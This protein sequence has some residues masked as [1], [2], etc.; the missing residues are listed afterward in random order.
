MSVRVVRKMM[1]PTHLSLWMHSDTPPK[2]MEGESNLIDELGK[3]MYALP[4][5]VP[6]KSDESCVNSSATVGT[7]PG[8]M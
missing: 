8:S 4:L 3:Q 2:D 7:E 5:P 6:L 1:Q